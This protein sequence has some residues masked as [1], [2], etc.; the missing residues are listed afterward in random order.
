MLQNLKLSGAVSSPFWL[1][2]HGEEQK[3]ILR[4]AYPTAWGPKLLR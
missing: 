3:Q 1:G 2:V 4:S